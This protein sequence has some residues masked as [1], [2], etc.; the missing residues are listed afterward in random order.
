MS[1][2]GKI[3]Y[4]HHEQHHHHD[5]DS[6][7]PPPPPPVVPEYGTFQGVPSSPA[8]G[9]PHPAP[10]PGAMDPSTNYYTRGYQ[11][12]PVNDDDQDMGTC[13]SK[14][15]NRDK[16]TNKQQLVSLCVKGKDEMLTF[17]LTA[18]L[19]K[20]MEGREQMIRK[21]NRV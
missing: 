15:L 5:Q 7:Q 6:D 8:M 11:A 10:P 17:I 13:Y 1:E 14:G 19:E 16:V 4:H 3:V 12:V 20:I 2:E 21:R 18:C 9:F